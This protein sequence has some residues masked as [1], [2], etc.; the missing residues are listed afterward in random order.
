MVQVAGRQIQGLVK[1]FGE[2][3]PGELVAML[4]SSGMLSICLVNGS[5]EALLG[6]QPGDPVEIIQ[7]P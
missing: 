7:Q 3:Q 1:T 2:G 4:D 5:A 6:A